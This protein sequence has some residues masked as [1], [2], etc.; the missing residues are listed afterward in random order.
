VLKIANNKCV[1]I[2]C[3]SDYNKLHRLSPCS[4]VCLRGRCVAYR[5]CIT[6]VFALLPQN[7]SQTKICGKFRTSKSIFLIYTFNAFATV[8]NTD[9]EDCI[10]QIMLMKSVVL[11]EWIF[12]NSTISSSIMCRHLINITYI[13]SIFM[14][15][16][17]KE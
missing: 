15:F 9:G 13:G 7:S 2:L 17:I 5:L 4:S 16:I 8:R 3:V 1:F 10:T 6:R 11:P 14:K 12:V